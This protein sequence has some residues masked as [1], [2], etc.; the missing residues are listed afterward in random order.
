M[1]AGPKNT[2]RFSQI[3]KYG[4]LSQPKFI[5]SNHIHLFSLIHTESERVEATNSSKNS[6]F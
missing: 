4:N 1:R 3:I 5:K 6:S 2:F